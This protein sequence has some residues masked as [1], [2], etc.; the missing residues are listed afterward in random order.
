MTCAADGLAHLVTD[1]AHAAG[2]AAGAGRYPALC[3]HQVAAAPLICPPGP[4]VPTL[5]GSPAPRPAAER[6]ASNPD[7]CAL[8]ATVLGRGPNGKAVIITV[9]A[10]GDQVQVR[11]GTGQAVSLSTE[12]AGDLLRALRAEFDQAASAL[13]DTLRPPKGRAARPYPGTRAKED[14]AP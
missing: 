10:R 4:T 14:D 6:S 12:Q 9:L 3:G 8:M 2:L 5:R 11:V 13:L 7:R 1:D